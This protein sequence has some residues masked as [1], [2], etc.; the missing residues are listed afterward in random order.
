MTPMEEISEF[1]AEERDRRAVRAWY[2]NMALFAVLA[3]VVVLGVLYGLGTG[4]F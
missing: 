3:V 2:G 1:I 4:A